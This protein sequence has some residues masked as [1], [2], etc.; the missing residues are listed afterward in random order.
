[1]KYDCEMIS[2]LLPLYKDGICSDVS[3]RAVEEHLRECPKCSKL[4]SAMSDTSLDERIIKEKNEVI[5]SQA[6][7]FKRKSALAGAIVGAVF[8]VPILVCLIVDI[9]A[10]S[11]L[12]W[13]FIVLASMLIPAT[14]SV[15]PL[16]VPR[17]KMFTTITSFTASVMLLLAV[18]CIYTRG[19]WF[20]VAAASVL[21]GLTLLF[22]PFIVCRRPVNSYLKNT[23]GLAIMGAYTLTFILMMLCIGLFVK[24][25][26]YN[27]LAASI[28]I[29]FLVVIWA[30]FA[31]IRYLPV[32]ALAKTGISV[33]LI[34]SLTYVPVKLALNAA[35]QIA[36]ATG[37]VRGSAPTALMMII[38]LAVG[39]LLTVIGIVIGMT[40]KGKRNEKV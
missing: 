31:A 34:S 38:G 5:D 13:F 29:P 19:N 11:G 23:K 21:F 1:M 12:S 28:C 20:F 3:K 26:L 35:G 9:A 2:D 6:K 32:N 39:L 25:A 4:L 18:I 10:G 24:S 40:R 8:A 33:A 37:V 16:M 7:F 14:L 30:V 17:Y 27:S 15:V 36:S 22:A